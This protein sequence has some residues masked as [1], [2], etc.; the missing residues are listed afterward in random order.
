MEFHSTT[1]ITF[2]GYLLALE[3]GGTRS[4]AALMDAAGRLVQ[5]HDASDVNTNFVSTEQA[6][7]AVLS[8]VRGVL[9]SA[10]VSGKAV[11]LVASALVGAHFGP[12][13][14]GALLPEAVFRHY[15]ERDVIFARA[16]IYHPHGI[17]VVAATGAT[18]FGVRLDDGREVFMGGWGALLGDEGSAYALGLLGLRAAARAYEG[19]LSASTRLVEAVCQHFGLHEATFR[20]ELVALAY[21]KPLSR[22]EIAGLA[23]GV[24][25]LAGEGDRVAAHLTAKV[26][27]DLA[28]LG[29]HACRRLFEEYETFDLVIAGGLANAGDLIL[30]PLQ[31]GLAQ[32]FPQARFMIGR[33]QPAVALGRLALF[34]LK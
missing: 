11:G 15:S 18:A 27:G 34:D 23:A 28:A 12:E 29:L 31:K 1:K 22:A 20:Q 21:Q 26:A 3:G 13:T 5:I 6:Q 17:A 24:T 19:R 25:R 33:E 32:E 8:A 7:Q 30:G 2:S 4:Q 9:E 10:G 16:G 14:L